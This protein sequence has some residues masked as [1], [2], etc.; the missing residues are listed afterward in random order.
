MREWA[1][2]ASAM[3]DSK[4]ARLMD[5]LNETVRPNGQWSRDRVIIFT[6]YR[7][8][9]KW[10]FE[11]LAPRGFTEGGRVMLLHGGLNTEERERI[12]NEGFIPVGWRP[13]SHRMAGRKRTG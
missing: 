4:A 11:M 3:L 5:W 7:A 6:E 2:H 12:K 10:L 13:R 8:T 9:Q 1:Q